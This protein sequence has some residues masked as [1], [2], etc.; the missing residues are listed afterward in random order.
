MGYDCA[1]TM[2]ICC[3]FLKLLWLHWLLPPLMFIVC[4]PCAR[5]FTSQRYVTDEW[6]LTM[7]CILPYIDGNNFVGMIALESNIDVDLVKVRR[8]ECGKRKDI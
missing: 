8:S 4:S 7:I 2:S 5:V 3:A 1:N 6:D